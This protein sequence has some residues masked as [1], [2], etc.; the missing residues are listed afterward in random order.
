MNWWIPCWQSPQH[1]SVVAEGVALA[2]PEQ[3]VLQ[4]LPARPQFLQLGEVGTA[5]FAREIQTSP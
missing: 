3:R 1:Y 5:S 4:L 2:G